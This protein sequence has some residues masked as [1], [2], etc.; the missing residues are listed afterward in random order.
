M[1][2]SKNATA[3]SNADIAESDDL[4]FSDIYEKAAEE[5]DVLPDNVEIVDA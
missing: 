3:K 5:A 2:Y 1:E 4:K